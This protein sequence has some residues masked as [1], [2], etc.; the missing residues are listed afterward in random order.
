MR[1][2]SLA[3]ILLLCQSA[4][5]VLAETLRCPELS[6]AVQVGACPAEEELRYTYTGYCSDNARMYSKETDECVT[7]DAYRRLKNVVLWESANGDFSAYISCDLPAASLKA[8]RAASVKV[9]KQGGMTRLICHYG[10]GIAFTHRTRSECKVA[11]DGSCA[12]DPA[13][14]QADCV[15]KA[16][17]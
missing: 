1:L 10:E 2:S 7:Y 3:L 13:A 12:A 9:A 6:A 5:A 11:G 14:C 15:A 17:P 8:S 16:K 4:P